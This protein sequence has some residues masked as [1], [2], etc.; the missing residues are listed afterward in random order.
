MKGRRDVLQEIS[1]KEQELRR[2]VAEA[3]HQAQETVQAAKL[4]AADIIA[5]AQRDSRNEAQRF[6]HEEIRKARQ[7]A[8]DLLAAARDR[9][10]C[11][12]ENAEVR[13]AAVAK[14]MV[15]LVLP[16]QPAHS[17]S[18]ATQRQD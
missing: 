4:Q 6:H 2:R 11:L 5:Q 17:G 8:D 13:I 7:E 15:S 9:A 1:Y 12:K 14:H 18:A 16:G 3:R 10:R